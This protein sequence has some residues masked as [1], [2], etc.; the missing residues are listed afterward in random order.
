MRPGAAIDVSGPNLDVRGR[1]GVTGGRGEGTLV[2]GIVLSELAKRK[3][4]RAARADFISENRE[5][6]A[7]AERMGLLDGIETH[8]RLKS[9]RK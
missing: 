6:S 3:G 4:S 9:G 5:L 7:V 8:Y 1:G 2:E